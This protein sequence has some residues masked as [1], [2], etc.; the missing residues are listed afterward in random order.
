[1]AEG[2]DAKSIEA[3]GW[4]QGAVLCPALSTIARGLA[5][6]SI[7]F[8]DDDWII[9]T[10][11]DCD[12]VHFK[13]ENEPFVEVLRARQLAGN[14]VDGNLAA[15][16]NPRQLEFLD[17]ND[18]APR[19]VH[20]YAHERWLV[21]REILLTGKPARVL[22]PRTARLLAEWIAKRYTRAAFPSAFDQRWRKELKRWFGILSK[23]SDL[24][25]G[26]Y[27]RLGTH[28]EL[29]DD[30]PYLC[31][32]ML[33]IPLNA[34]NRPTWVQERAAIENDVE[35]F[36]KGF[37]PRIQCA[38]VEVYLTD[39][40]TLADLNDYLRFDADWVSFADDGPIVPIGVGAGR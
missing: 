4:R 1:M 38:G 36:W 35:S 34:R 39:E 29:P 22:V 13:L 6:A 23:H 14:R 28:D 40:I 10:S 7:K 21:P 19:L 2:F 20:C 25:Q 31:H 33:A 24:I 16:R 26:V 5:P 15:G 12:L 32:L 30:R 8:G 17:E 18:S 11:H 3:Q 27:L 9:V 37:E